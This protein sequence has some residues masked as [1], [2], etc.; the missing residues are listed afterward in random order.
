MECRLGE[1]CSPHW[2]PESRQGPS[3]THCTAKKE[4]TWRLLLSKLP[5]VQQ[6]SRV[7]GPSLEA[8]GQAEVPESCVGRA[9]FPIKH[10]EMSPFR[11]G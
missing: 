2:K 5:E 3:I 9:H 11:S 10:M 7:Q 4:L 8:E 6:L 1:W